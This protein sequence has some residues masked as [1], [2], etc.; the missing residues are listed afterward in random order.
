MK[1]IK[2]TTLIYLKKGLKTIPLC[3]VMGLAAGLLFGF[4][5]GCLVCGISTF[6]VSNHYLNIL[7]IDMEE[8]SINTLKDNK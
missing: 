8:K 1:I 4:A 5:Y 7:Y 6:I 3:V 2:P